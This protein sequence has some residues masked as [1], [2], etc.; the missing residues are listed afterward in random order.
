MQVQADAVGAAP[1]SQVLWSRAWPDQ[2]VFTFF[3]LKYF[4]PNDSCKRVNQCIKL[5]KP[6]AFQSPHPSQRGCGYDKPCAQ[7][8]LATITKGLC[9]NS[10]KIHLGVNFHC[11]MLT[12][13]NWDLLCILNTSWLICA[14][15]YVNV[16]CCL[17]CWV[18]FN[19]PNGPGCPRNVIIC[20]TTWS[21]AHSHCKAK[22][23]VYIWQ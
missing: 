13:V 18:F 3:F 20:R 16:S 1:V 2:S 14:A 6:E 9:E 8:E 17:L 11:C 5:D 23:L 22:Q 15:L 10:V 21:S 19:S 4:A 7:P 12:P